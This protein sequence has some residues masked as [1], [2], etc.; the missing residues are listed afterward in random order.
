MTILDTFFILFESDAAKL[1]KGLKDSEKKAEGLGAK[2]TDVD[3]K[4]A[5]MGA[6][7]LASIAALAGTAL[8]A[9]GVASLT[10]N[11]IEAS[12]A[13][14]KLNE[15]TQRLGLN[16]EEVSAWGDLTKKNG[17]STEAFVGSIEN[18]NKALSTMEVT[19]KSRAAPFLKD[20][21][22][23]LDLAAN[24][25][26]TA[27]DFLPQIADAFSKMDKQKSVAIGQRLG[28]DNGTI[29]TLQAGRREVEAL[30]AKERELG[31]ITEKQGQIADDY[32][33]SL[34]DLRH[35]MRSV[36]LG[37]SEYILPALTWTINKFK[38]GAVFAREHSDAVVG[39]MIAL[40]SAITVY[41]LPPM[42]RL[43]AATLVT[44]AP[45]ILIGALVVGL[46]AA[47]ALLYEDIMIF[48]EGGDS[49][50]GQMLERWPVI[51]DIAHGIGAAFTGLWDIMKAVAGFMADMWNDPIAA[52]SKF[53]DT[54]KAGLNMIP[55]FGAV[56]DAVNMGASAF[57][58][59][60]AS[61]LG[62]AT[63]ASITNGGASNKSTT[64]Q[65]DRVDVST[66]AGD[67]VGISRSIGDALGSQ[68][69]QTI[70][71]LDDGV[72]A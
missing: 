3:A 2:L 12:E 31:V 65:I 1:D 71:N 26:K 20:L 37:V 35:A 24:K 7:F 17:G 14:D 43:A 15:S 23:N 34:D 30:L 40:G 25:G 51:G 68:M 57:A 11:V 6:S 60:S 58:A 45:F 8:A 46:A 13:A 69:Q 38:D 32:G 72:I 48:M 33:D 4:A 21:G 10:H 9:V 64:V 29:M 44:A 19:G 62:S 53:L 49:M 63:S 50:I 18:L 56:M 22:I 52:F 16:I 42:I 59:A 70:N 55:G 61:P 47:F 36:W 66:G 39:F 41:A 67:A 5:H 54:V 28:F 27:M